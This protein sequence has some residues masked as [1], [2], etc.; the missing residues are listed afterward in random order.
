[1]PA[2]NHEPAQIDVELLLTSDARARLS[3]LQLLRLYFDPGALFKDASRG[4]T[5][6]REP[7]LAYNSRIRWILIAHSLMRFCHSLSC[8][9]TSSLDMPYIS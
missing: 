5:Y 9:S 1:M 4:S 6:W 2:L 3:T 7:A 8:F